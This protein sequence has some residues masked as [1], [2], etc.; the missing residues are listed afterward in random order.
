MISATCT[1][2][3]GSVLAALSSWCA[4]ACASDADDSDVRHA[5]HLNRQMRQK[6]E[7]LPN[8]FEKFGIW[9]FTSEL[10]K[11]QN[12]TFVSQRH[13]LT[14]IIAVHNELNNPKPTTLL[15]QAWQ[16]AS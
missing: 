7:P 11:Q 13:I 8:F 1:L 15:W 16:E 6:P 10:P 5:A 12:Q 2:R 14:F 9:D 4:P 3:L